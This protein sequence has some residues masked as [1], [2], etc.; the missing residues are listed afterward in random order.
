MQFFSAYNTDIGIKRKINQDS[1]VIRHAS[2]AKGEVIMVV[3]C[4][5]MGGFAAGEL[6]SKE[7]VLRL[8]LWFKDDLPDYIYSELNAEILKKDWGRILRD[9]DEVLS[10]YADKS[11]AMLGTTVTALLLFEDHYYIAHVGDSRCYQIFKDSVKQITEDD[12][13]VESEL[14]NGIITPEEAITDTRRNILTNCVG[15]ERG[16]TPGFYEG[17]TGDSIGFLVCTDGFWHKNSL[18]DLKEVSE[19]LLTGESEKLQH[20]LAARTE[21]AKKKQEKDNITAAAVGIKGV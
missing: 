6:A 5:G 9:Q 17:E 14:R 3:V 21:D 16:V 13:V 10:R 11:G 20:A 12:S 1:L 2:T 15:G 18:E 4:D 8:A 7:M 19:A